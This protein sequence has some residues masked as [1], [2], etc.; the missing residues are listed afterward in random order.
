MLLQLANRI[1]LTRAEKET[2]KYMNEA[3][4]KQQ[5]I[6]KLRSGDEDTEKRLQKGKEYWDRSRRVAVL[7]RRLD[8]RIDSLIEDLR[9]IVKSYTLKSWARQRSPKLVSVT[10]L[11]QAL[12]DIKKWGLDY[13]KTRVRIQTTGRQRKYWLDTNFKLKESTNRDIFAPEFALTGIK[14]YWVNSPGKGSKRI[15]IRQ[16]LYNVLELERGRQREILP[17]KQAEALSIFQLFNLL[18]D[19]EKNPKKFK[20]MTV[21]KQEYL[22]PGEYNLDEITGE[23]IR[24]G[25]G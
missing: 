15:R 18:H 25:A 16:V 3:R 23:L 17:R 22:E 12:E 14:N 11:L 13:S 2:I 1:L 24:A 7:T 10:L 5:E 9:I 21:Q 20:K 8:E 19:A 6:Y 4:Q